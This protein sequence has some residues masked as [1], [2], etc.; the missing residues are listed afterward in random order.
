MGFHVALSFAHSRAELA[1]HSVMFVGLVIAL[2]FFTPRLSS[3]V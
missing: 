3:Q 2:F 1:I